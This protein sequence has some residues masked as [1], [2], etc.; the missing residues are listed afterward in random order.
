MIGMSARP[1]D[2]DPIP[3]RPLPGSYWVEPGRLLVGEFPGS[4]SRADTMDRLKQVLAAGITQFVDLTDATEL[5]SYEALL[6][7][8][9][10]SGRR[11]QYMRESIPDHGVPVSAVTM[12]RIVA[13]LRNALDAGEVVYLHCRAGI[14]R[15]AMVAA[16]YFV[17]RGMSA[18]AALEALQ[19]CWKQSAKSQHWVCVPETED[20]YEYIREWARRTGTQMA[21]PPLRRQSDHAPIVARIRG[22]LFGLAVGDTMGALHAGGGRR[23]D[24]AHGA[25]TLRGREPARA[26]A[27]RSAR[28]RW[29]GSCS[30]SADISRAGEKTAMPVSDDIS[31][32]LATY[33]WRGIATAGSHDPRDRSGSS[34]SRALPAALYACDD[35]AAA[36]ALAAECSRTTHQGPVVLDVCRY[37]AAMFVGAL[38]GAGVAVALERYEPSDGLWTHRPLKHEVEEAATAVPL[39]DS[40]A[41]SRGVDVLRTL[42]NARRVLMLSSEFET[43]VGEATRVAVDPALDGAITGALAGAIFGSTAIPAALLATRAASRCARPACRS[44]RGSARGW[45]HTGAQGPVTSM[46]AR[47]RVRGRS[48]RRAA[49]VREPA[50]TRLSDEQLLQRRFSSLRLTLTDSRL[51]ASVRRVYAELGAKGIRFRPHVW[52]S[53]EW[54]SPDGIPGIAIPFYLAHPRLMQLERR[55][56]REVEGGNDKWLMR[57]LRHETGHAIDTAFGLRRRKAWR[58]VFGKAS[59]RYPSRYSPRPASRRLRA[60]PRSLVRAEPPDRRLRRDLRGLAASRAHA[61]AASTRAGRR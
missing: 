54:F 4:R 39:A 40:V 10:P 48:R 13:T 6:P 20:Q 3:A 59:R 46:A 19:K 2:E 21:P 52:L 60:A 25:R 30:G 28:T 49:R 22:A 55:I 27:V 18:E 58:T 34:L 51:E 23:L 41:T 61:G 8:A 33:R 32:A 50:W 37:L 5:P 11:V 45:L 12:E 35:P 24:A 44:V 36:V 16:C 47:A 17:E 31:R 38:Q 42:A 26:A 57:I 29:S 14:G 15:S 56:M 9:T 53:E 7:F 1:P 43:I